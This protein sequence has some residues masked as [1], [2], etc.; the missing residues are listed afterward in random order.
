MNEAC[1]AHPDRPS[2]ARC[3]R[4]GRRLCDA[5]WAF[6][7]NESD[8]WCARCAV[9]VRSGEVGPLARAGVFV[10]ASA[11]MLGVAAFSTWSGGSEGTAVAIGVLG[12]VV[13]TLVSWWL[14]RRPSAEGPPIRERADDDPIPEGPRALERARGAYRAR[15]AD[16]AVRA[17]PM[18][19][20]R[21]TA[22]AVLAALGVCLLLFPAALR[23]PRWVEVELGL[24]LFW[25]ALAVF[26]SVILYRGVRLREDH[27]LLLPWNQS[28]KAAGKGSGC[29]GCDLG[30]GCDVGG[31]A[32]GLAVVVVVVVV[33]VVAVGLA[34]V[35]VELVAPLL[36]FLAYEAIVRAIDRAG[37]DRHDCAGD[38][39]RSALWGAL[40]ALIYVAPFATLTW[41][42]HAVLA[43][44]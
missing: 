34:W 42:V 20:A 32:E 23:L 39:A 7:A 24:G 31:D 16:V 19:S 29:D 6:V 1:G 2:V 12:A 37:R 14:A 22:L 41:V 3:R 9:R 30:S 26:L 18:F 21:A 11:M 17:L 4:C 33:A 27:A 43:R 44:R 28:S 5:C 10:L 38:A 40:W 15:V 8:P 13:T 36:F 35:V 25:L